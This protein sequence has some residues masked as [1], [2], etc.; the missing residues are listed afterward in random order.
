MS[1]QMNRRDFL[2]TA[3]ISS[4]ALAVG[5]STLRGAES[6][7]AARLPRR[8]YKPGVEI[9]IIGF[10]GLMLRKPLMDQ[11]NANRVVAKAYERGCNY[12]DVA[13]AYGDA[14]EKL[15]P[16][17]EP[18]RKNCFLS[19]KTKARDAA[20]CKKDLDNSL[21]LLRTDHFE[22]YQMHVI[23][24]PQKDV[25]AAFMKGGAMETILQARK[26]GVIRYVGV[27]AHTTEAALAAMNRFDFDSIMFP[28]NYASIYKGNFGSEILELAKKKNC[29]CIG[30][31]SLCRQEW[32]AGANR[33]KWRHLWYEPLSDPTEADLGL[34]WALSQDIVT[35]IPPGD[36]TVQFLAFDIAAR[37]K[38]ITPEEQQQVQ[39]LAARM[40]PLFRAGKVTG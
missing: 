29:A 26:A 33:G 8:E 22:L 14:Q 21:K 4:T 37:Y 28:L 35:T 16:A 23:K 13:P 9:S 38:P 27:T 12:F 39:A 11:D 5:A 18:Y 20:G 6:G 40:T 31:K 25:D 34:R 32:P 15:G 17:L 19:C 36:E 3:A 10:A 24:D 7:N 2:K 1:E 30:I